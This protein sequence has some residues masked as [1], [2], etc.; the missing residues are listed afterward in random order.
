MRKLRSTKKGNLFWK[1]KHLFLLKVHTILA[2][3]S[4]F[5]AINFAFIGE[6][7]WM[8]SIYQQRFTSILEATQ[9]I[10]EC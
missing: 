6:G 7:S 10:L 8:K 9:K 3:N 5:I 2:I 4:G 1:G